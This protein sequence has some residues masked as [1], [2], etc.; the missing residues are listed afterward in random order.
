MTRL[1][2]TRCERRMPPGGLRLDG[3]AGHDEHARSTIRQ[4]R[5]PSHT[6]RRARWG[7]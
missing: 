2:N 3:A 7:R 6:I 4:P 1:S 5:R